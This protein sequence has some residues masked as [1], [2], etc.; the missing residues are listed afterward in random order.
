MEEFLF[1]LILIEIA[2]EF[3]P[4]WNFVK[5]LVLRFFDKFENKLNLV[6]LTTCWWD[7]SDRV[8]L[9]STNLHNQNLS[10]SFIFNLP[11]KSSLNFLLSHGLFR[12]AGAPDWNIL[13]AVVNRIICSPSFLPSACYVSYLFLTEIWA[14][15]P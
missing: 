15:I 14:A 11:E 1:A 7:I 4:S 9:L 5:L 3:Y 12:I 13:A 6:H 10:I 2:V 8:G